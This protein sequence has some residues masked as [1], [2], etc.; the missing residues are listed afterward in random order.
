MPLVKEVFQIIPDI[1]TLHLERGFSR[2]LEEILVVEQVGL[3]GPPA[4]VCDLQM[5]FVGFKGGYGVHYY[6]PYFSHREY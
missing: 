1:G 4:I 3:D 2:K 6:S 5:L